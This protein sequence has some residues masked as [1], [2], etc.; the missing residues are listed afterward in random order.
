MLIHAPKTIWRQ[1]RQNYFFV[2]KLVQRIWAE[3]GALRNDLSIFLQCL[4]FE[5]T[6]FLSSFPWKNRWRTVGFAHQGEQTLRVKDRLRQLAMCEQEGEGG[7]S[8]CPMSAK[9]HHDQDD[10]YL[11]CL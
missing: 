6:Y 4:S 3:E 11:K 7:L 9:G 10:F 2:Q 1:L 5:T 8:H